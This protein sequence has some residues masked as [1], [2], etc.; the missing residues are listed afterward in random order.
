MQTKL[1]DVSSVFAKRLA[2]NRGPIPGDPVH[3]QPP[4][5]GVEAHCDGERLFLTLTFQ[6]GS[7][8]CCSI[9]GCHLDYQ[10]SKRWDALRDDLMRLGLS[11]PNRIH[12]QIAVI[13]E[14]GALFFD[15]SRPDPLRRGWYEFVA[16]D[17]VRYED[18]IVEGETGCP[19][20]DAKPN[21]SST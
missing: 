20:A 12:L 3:R 9:W 19:Q 17:V 11:V 6:A 4:N 18:S 10:P 5:Y 2:R 1:V 7:A 21:A 8:Y 15:M 14:K 16:R 13:V